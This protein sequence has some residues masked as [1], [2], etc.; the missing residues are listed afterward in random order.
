LDGFFLKVGNF[1]IQLWDFISRRGISDEFAENARMIMLMNRVAVL[2]SLGAFILSNMVFWNT[3]DTVYASF[4][5]AAV[6]IY[7]LI[8]ILHHFNK[9]RWVRFYCA[10]VLSLWFMS[11][12]LC[13]GGYLS[14]SAGCLAILIITYVLLDKERKLRVK[15]LLYNI[16]LYIFVTTYLV[17]YPPLFGVR[18]YP[19]DEIVVFFL[20]VKW[21]FVVLLTYQSEKETL[22]KNL[23]EKNKALGQTTE[24]LERFTYIAS[25]DLK[26]PLR[27]VIS[28]LGL[29]ERK[30][31]K[32]QYHDVSDDLE[33][34]KKGAEQMYYLVSDILELSRINVNSQEQR[35]W[36]DLNDVIQKSISNLRQDISE[37]NAVVNIPDLPAYLCNS[38]EFALV[39][40]NIIQNGIKYNESAT[41]T[42]NVRTEQ[43]D[44]QLLIHFE[45]NG[46][47]IK[48]EYFDR[49]FQFFKRLHT[50]DKYKGTGLG[51]GLCKKII[52]NYNGHISVQSNIGSGS[53]FTL[54]LPHLVQTEMTKKGTAL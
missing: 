8:P 50:H 38:V 49:I 28:F 19:L 17:F 46:I 15:F 51:L 9:I 24:E 26:S 30:I 25:H 48:E 32:G 3:R 18:D 5:G 13:V 14:Q 12:L 20:C 31:E 54:Q 29:A 42:V 34:A 40:Q 4:M 11:M 22:I 27:T 7:G 2:S 1:A 10:T 23:Q 52:Q 6:V 53:I 47:G 21:V 45:D 33:F 36:T 39:F 44:K 35:E 41:P 37:K 16:L 43:T